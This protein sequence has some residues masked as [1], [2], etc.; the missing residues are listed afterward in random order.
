METNEAGEVLKLVL[1]VYARQMAM[2]DLLR[3][4]NLSEDQMNEALARAK[5]RLAKVPRLAYLA[6]PSPSDI[7]GLARLLGGIQWPEK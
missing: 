7:R 6:N 5:P 4:L 3:Q 1:G 2:L